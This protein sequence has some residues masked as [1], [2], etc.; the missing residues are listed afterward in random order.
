M[1]WPK[2]FLTKPS[3]AKKAYAY[4]LE[5]TTESFRVEQGLDKLLLD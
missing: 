3:A 5:L 2:S 1:N 4:I